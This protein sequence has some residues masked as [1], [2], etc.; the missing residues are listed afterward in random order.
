M[1]DLKKEFTKK[2]PQ[3]I[4]PDGAFLIRSDADHKEIIDFIRQREKKLLNS[5]DDLLRGLAAIVYQNKGEIKVKESSLL[6]MPSKWEIHIEED[7]SNG[8]KIIKLKE[9][10]NE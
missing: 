5:Q 2:F 6:T 3:Y 10:S 4:G 8:D 1:I 7:L 9:L